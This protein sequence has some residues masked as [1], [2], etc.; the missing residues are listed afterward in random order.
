M[1]FP[2]SAARAVLV[3][4][5]SSYRDASS[6]LASHTVAREAVQAVYDLRSSGSVAR[7]FSGCQE[8]F[9]RLATFAAGGADLSCGVKVEVV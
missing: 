8:V 1:V 3:V 5:R 7:D 2:L 6:I 9:Q 4:V